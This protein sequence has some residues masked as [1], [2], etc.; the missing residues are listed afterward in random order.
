MFKPNHL[1][2]G[3]R[4]ASLFVITALALFLCVTTASA[5]TPPPIPANAN[6]QTT[7][8]F[9]R[10]MAGLGGVAENT[11]W[12][13]G[14]VNHSRYTAENNV[15][16]HTETVGNPYYTASGDLAAQNGNVALFFGSL[17]SAALTGRSSSS[18]LPGR[19]TQSA[20]SIRSW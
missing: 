7:V 8:N 17:P 10:A 5:D 12:S 15:V 6:W 9:Y 19:F 20:S 1:W 16:T 3:P 4:R 14:D 2:R 13:M 11:T 18:G